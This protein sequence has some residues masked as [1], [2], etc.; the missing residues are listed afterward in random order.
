MSEFE[1][2]SQSFEVEPVTTSLYFLSYN[3]NS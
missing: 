2:T 1:M 3:V